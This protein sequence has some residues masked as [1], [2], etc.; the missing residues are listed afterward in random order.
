MEG[1]DSI[2]DTWAPDASF[3]TKPLEQQYLKSLYW[4]V[5]VVT[6][7]SLNPPENS[8]QTIFNIIC[9]V[10]GVFM[11]GAIVGSATSALN[12]LDSTDRPFREKMEVFLI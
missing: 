9:I 2:D 3:L 1:L 12:K 8:I 6:K 4:A 10:L 7:G 5:V 11:Y